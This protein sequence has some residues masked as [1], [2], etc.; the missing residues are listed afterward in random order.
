MTEACGGAPVNPYD[1]CFAH[2]APHERASYL[3]GLVTGGDLDFQGVTFTHELLDELLPRLRQLSAFNEARFS[4]AKFL[5]PVNL[6]RISFQGT[7]WFDNAEFHD[8]VT[9]ENASLHPTG[10]FTGCK[11]NGAANFKHSSMGDIDFSGAQFRSVDF[12]KISYAASLNF[13]DAIFAEFATFEQSHINAAQ[14]TRSRF[15]RCAFWATKFTTSPSFNE[16]NFLGLTSF[17]KSDFDDGADFSQATFENATFKEAKFSGVAMFRRAK[18]KSAYMH[19]AHFASIAAFNMTYVTEG[20][21]FA[22]CRFGS[23]LLGPLRARELNMPNSVFQST[24]RIEVATESL[25][26]RGAKFE[27]PAA[28]HVRYALVDVAD[29]NPSFPVTIASHGKNFEG[30]GQALPE[31][32]SGEALAKIRSLKGVDAALIILNDIDL[33]KCRF[34]GSYHLDQ[35]N[36][37]GRCRFSSPPQE[38]KFG[39]ALIPLRIWTQRKVLEEERA[40]RASTPSRALDK[41]G[42]GDPIPAPAVADSQDIA[43]TYRQLR[44]ALEDSLNEPGAADFYYGEMEM[45]RRD[46]EIS[47]SERGLLHAYWALSGYGLRASRSIGWLVSAMAVTV[48]LMMG[49]GLPGSEPKQE[50]TGIIAPPGTKTT[51]VLDKA[52]PN[53]DLPL[54]DRFTGR[55]LEKAGRV[56]LNSV[57]FRSSGQDLTDSGT[58]IEMI[59]RF[60]EPVLL[61]FAALAVRG[62]I[63]R[64]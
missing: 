46:D 63:K 43:A 8:S 24:V 19:R 33:R 31:D 53:L 25:N 44:K 13:T 2:L 14:F 22:G 26:L 6:S 56:V 29:I 61:G 58:W 62:R 37:E 42:W 54:P 5:A 30:G 50:A 59:S 60:T 32:L 16:A 48:L 64:S 49:W 36:L 12:S 18:F 20:L 7:H 3:D 27:A 34:E 1:R 9:F 45:R 11:F 10:S 39:R 38:A 55:R 15:N 35:I 52:N 21:D 28:F 47:R 4:R 57:I 17:E 23:Y 41:A 40:W 51:L